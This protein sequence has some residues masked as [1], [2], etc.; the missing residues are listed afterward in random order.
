MYEKGGDARSAHIDGPLAEST[1]A[2][3]FLRMLEIKLLVPRVMSHYFRA[4]DSSGGKRPER[5]RALGEISTGPVRWV[6]I[7]LESR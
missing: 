1:I 6:T 3:C 5:D 7:A 4:G 2:A